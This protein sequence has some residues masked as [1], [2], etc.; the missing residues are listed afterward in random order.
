[1]IPMTN[2]TWDLIKVYKFIKVYKSITKIFTKLRMTKIPKPKKKKR[3]KYRSCHLRRQRVGLR[4]D[5]R[6]T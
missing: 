4:A 2:H 5:G 3:K 6:E 1:M